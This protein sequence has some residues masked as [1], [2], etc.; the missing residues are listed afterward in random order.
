[1]R[2]A[3]CFND[4]IL[5]RAVKMPSS[6]T[7]ALLTIAVA[8]LF[9]GCAGSKGSTKKVSSSSYVYC[10]GVNSCKGQGF[11]DIDEETC[12]KIEGGRLTP[13]KK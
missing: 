3:A 12:L 13:E 8:G 11:L 6:T 5:R 2:A 10:G 1:M 4:F 9:A 7:K